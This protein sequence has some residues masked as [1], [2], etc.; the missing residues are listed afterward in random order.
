M[1]S[2]LWNN[3]AVRGGQ[4]YGP[5]FC[6]SDTIPESRVFSIQLGTFLHDVELRNITFST[7]VLSIEECNARGF[8]IQEH[9]F[10]NKTK[11]FSLKVPFD[12]D[13]VLTHVWTCGQ[14]KKNANCGSSINL[15]SVYLQNPE[16]LVTEYTLPLSF[17]FV[18][19]PE[20]TTFSHT[21]QLQASL[22]D[23]GEMPNFCGLLLH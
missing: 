11:Q 15:T 3:S 12:T 19:M 17:G 2:K 5:A 16:V 20:E 13:V 14:K 18:V 23:V 22:Q 1:V 8:D 21:V 9:R 6:F 10:P 4:I 7:G